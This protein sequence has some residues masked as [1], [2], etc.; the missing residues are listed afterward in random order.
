MYEQDYIIRLVKNLVKFVLKAFLKKEE[1]K[2][3]Y[4][5]EENLS[6]TDLLHRRIL[7]LISQGKINEAENLLFEE[8][9]PNNIK[10]L[11]LAIDFYNRIN[12]MEDEFLEE[13]NFSR[14]EVEEG[15]KDVLKEFGINM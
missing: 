2:Y 11:E 10:Y 7:D 14:K 5:D 12:E 4:T 1:A 6:Q 3:E 15:L 13:N 8:I 9:D